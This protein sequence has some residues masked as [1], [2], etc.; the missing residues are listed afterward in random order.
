MRPPIQEY[1]QAELSLSDDDNEDTKAKHAS[2]STGQFE[3]KEVA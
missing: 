1:S 2:A 3:A